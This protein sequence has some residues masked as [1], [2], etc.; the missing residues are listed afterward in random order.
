VT[1]RIP[2]A[3][4]WTLE[5]HSKDGE[6]ARMYTPE[7]ERWRLVERTEEEMLIAWATWTFRL[8]MAVIDKEMGQ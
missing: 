4:G 5:P 3:D 1:D 6:P 2:L 7:G 8:E